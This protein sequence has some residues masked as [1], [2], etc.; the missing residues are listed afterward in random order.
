MQ[1]VENYF[2]CIGMLTYIQKNR[3][4]FILFKYVC[5]SLYIPTSFVCV[6]R[7]SMYKNETSHLIEDNNKN[8]W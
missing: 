1:G 4:T 2:I 7:Y 6:W 3:K 8:D 5:F